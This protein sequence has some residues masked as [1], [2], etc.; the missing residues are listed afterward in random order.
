MP[1]MD[2]RIEICIVVPEMGAWITVRLV[3][4]Y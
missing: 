1:G 4:T 3:E 2:H